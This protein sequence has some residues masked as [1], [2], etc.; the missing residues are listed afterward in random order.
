MSRQQ[1]SKQRKERKLLWVDLEMT[2]LDP[3]V[4]RVV[5]IACLITDKHLNVI[6]EGFNI[7][8][9]HDN[10]V[11]EMMNTKVK[12]MHTDSGLVEAIKES[13]VSE[14]EA[15][16]HFFKYV[17]KHLDQHE[18]LLAGNSI[19]YDSKFIEQYFPKVSKYLHY[20]LV[21]VTGIKELVLSWYPELH[22]FEKKKSHRALDDILE[23]I[24][25]LKFYKRQVFK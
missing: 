8:I 1:N 13:E 15:Y 25:E 4:D 20:R 9:H 24:E 12:E 16:E 17:T 2:G 19:H 18:A 23:S 11:L 6:D 7:I 21:D 10:S 22:E 5:E 14:D 3:K